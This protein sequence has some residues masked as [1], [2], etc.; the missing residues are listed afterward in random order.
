MGK[1]MA[2][3]SDNLPSFE[4]LLRENLKLRRELGAEIAKARGDSKSQRVTRGFQR[5][6]LF[7]AVIPLLLF[8]RGR[9]S[10]AT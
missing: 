10:S 1:N 3:D 8:R 4:E 7:L 6:A 5:L 2:S 9:S